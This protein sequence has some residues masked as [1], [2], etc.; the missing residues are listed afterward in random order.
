MGGTPTPPFG[1]VFTAD[2]VSGLAFYHLIFIYREI[3]KK[4]I[5]YCLTYKLSKH[6]L[7]Q[8]QCIRPFHHSCFYL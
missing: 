6:L 2:A 4:R 1:V 7:T 5:I 8:A 3:G